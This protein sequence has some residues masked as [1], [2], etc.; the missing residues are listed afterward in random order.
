MGNIRLSTAPAL[1]AALLWWPLVAGAQAVADPTPPGN[2]RGVDASIRPGDFFAYADGDWLKAT[3]IPAGKERWGARNDIDQLTR[4]QVL[5]LLDD[6][7]A[8][9]VGSLA[10]KVADFRTAYLNEGVI[11]AKGITPLQPLLDRIG[12]VQDKMALTRLLGSELGADVDPLNYGVYRSSHLLGLSVEPGI[13]GEKTYVAFLVQGGLGLPNREYYLSTDPHMQVLRAKYQ[14]Y[15]GHMLTLA[16]FKRG[17]RRAEAVM[18]LETAIAQSHATPEASANDRNADHLWTRADFARQ[19]PGMDWSAFFAAAGLARQGA[20]VAWQ[21]SAVQGVA[22]LV[23][24]QPLEAWKDYLRFHAVD[25]QAEVLPRAFAEAASALHGEVAGQPDAGSRAQRALEATQSAMSDAIGQMYAERHFSAGQ[26]ARVQAVVAN[27]VAAFTRRVETVTWMSPGTR[28][29][30]LAKLKT[31]YVG[32]GYPEHW[33]DYSDLAVDPLDAVGNRRR[34]ADRTYRHAVARLG[35]PVDLTEWWIAPQT[36]GAV[37]IFQQNAYDFAAGLLQAPKFDSAASD[38]ETYGAIGALIGHDVSHFVDVL[39]A[40][41]DTAG[42]ERRWWTSQDSVRFEASADPLVQ[43]FSTYRPFPDLAINGKLTET[44]NV[45]DLAG[46]SAAFDA[47]RRT[48][49]NRAGDTEYV[50]EQDR[51]FFIGFARSWRSKIGEGAMR[52]QVATNNHAP[53]TYRVA[54]VRNMD[55][56]YEAF[57]VQPGQRLYLEPGARVRIW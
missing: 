48:L 44:E 7:T 34:V 16:G 32:V 26:K 25:A 37:L 45:A 23:A 33:A 50:R 18:R 3:A 46:L 29:L 41:Y 11:E 1:A 56:W 38:A 27:V 2:E 14:Q 55:A 13:N 4:Q 8:A 10:R 52:T 53:E 24:A 5:A 40:E 47:Y 6:A 21:P 22:A 9:P 17:D 19:A 42:R 30:A 39:G 36:V 20:F 51:Q 43:Q 15:I 54:T 49:G 31:L 35:T 57:D 28:A 12:G